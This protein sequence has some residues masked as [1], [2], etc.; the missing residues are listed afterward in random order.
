MTECWGSYFRMSNTVASKEVFEDIKAAIEKF[1]EQAPKRFQA[2]LKVLSENTE[3][4][5]ETNELFYGKKDD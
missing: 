5:K 2:W 1:N 3:L 4:L